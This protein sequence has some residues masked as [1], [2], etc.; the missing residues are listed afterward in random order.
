[1]ENSLPENS[2]RKTKDAPEG[3]EKTIFTWRNFNTKIVFGEVPAEIASLTPD[4]LKASPDESHQDKE[5]K[6]TSVEVVLREPVLESRK[7]SDVKMMP[8]EPASGSDL[9]DQTSGLK[10]ENASEENVAPESDSEKG[11]SKNGEIQGGAEPFSNGTIL[12][13]AE[14]Y[15]VE[16]LLG[17]GGFGDIYK[18]VST[19]NQLQEERVLKLLRSSDSTSQTADELQDTYQSQ[20]KAWKVLSDKEPDYIVK[21]F[22]VKK[23]ECFDGRAGRQ[24][25]GVF[26]EYMPGGNLWELVKSWGGKPQTNEQ[27]RQ[28]LLIFVQIC[29]AVN[30]IH[31]HK[32]IHGDIKPQNF[33]LDATKQNCKICDFELMTVNTV[34]KRSYLAG[35][36]RFMSPEFR[37]GEISVASDI[38]ALGVTF[39]LLLSGRFPYQDLDNE[40]SQS[41]FTAR[42]WENFSVGQSIKTSPNGELKHSPNNQSVKPLAELNPLVPPSLNRIVQRCLD[43]E[44]INRPSSIEDLLHEILELGIEERN[45]APVKLAQLLNEHLTETERT[46]L[47]AELKDK[48]YKSKSADP[49]QR[50]RDMIEEFCFT[51]SPYEILSQNCGIDSLYKIAASLALK[52]RKLNR[53]ELKEEILASIGFSNAE[54]KIHGF[55]TVRS[56]LKELL[57]KFEDATNAGE[58]RGHLLEAFTEIEH[59][60]GL[61]VS[62]YGQMFYGTGLNNFLRQ[63]VRGKPTDRLTFGEKIGALDK[64]SFQPPSFPLAERIKRSFAFPLLPGLISEKLEEIRMSRNRLVHPSPKTTK[65][66][67]EKS[68]GQQE[69][70]NCL[71]VA[72]YFTKAPA[73]RLLQI[74]AFHTDVF[75]RHSYEGRDEKKRREKIYTTQ[76]LRVGQIYLFYPLTNPACVNPLIFPI[77]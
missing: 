8:D 55:E 54:R 31:Q 60:V 40:P 61:L 57:E 12:S 45:L 72:E 1:M 39:Y 58:R 23:V 18:V 56:N 3:W 28:L 25:V 44:L 47:E 21:L 22:T 36:P 29:R 43:Q 65:R 2:N 62:F 71:E 16:K 24:Q 13:V 50:Q 4:Q 32:L 15:V 37:N 14:S 35:T 7:T 51:D 48:G 70:Q 19:E 67:G 59:A 53:E 75:G 20:Y 38:Y 9:S 52:T 77:E 27:M 73:P 69:L 6:F 46:V 63:H 68:F 74:I 26:M 33:L 30:V 17:R 49:K 66:L 42:W 11:K 5:P 41:G 76:S 10:P 64:L 34:V